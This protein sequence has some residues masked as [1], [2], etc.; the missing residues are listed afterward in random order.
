MCVPREVA[1]RRSAAAERVGTKIT[2]VGH[3]SDGWPGVVLR[4]E[5]RKQ[6]LTGF[7]HRW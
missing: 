4:H 5:G 3:V 7:E 6:T 1:E 2:W